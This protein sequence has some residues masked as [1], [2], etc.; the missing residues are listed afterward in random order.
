M[1]DRIIYAYPKSTNSS[2]LRVTVDGRELGFI[3][4]DG[5]GRWVAG[6]EDP[7]R[8]P[9]WPTPEEAIAWLLSQ[10]AQPADSQA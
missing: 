3:L 9:S 8:P 2:V 1:P 7:L 4:H 5:P 10:D 6:R